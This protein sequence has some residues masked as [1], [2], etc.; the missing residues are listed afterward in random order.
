[1]ITKTSGSS[2]TNN[3]SRLWNGY[4]VEL[5]LVGKLAV[6]VGGGAVALRRTRALAPSNSLRD[7][8]EMLPVTK[9]GNATGCA[10][11]AV[12]SSACRAGCRP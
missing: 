8:T 10:S 1:M 6:V 7:T 5:D 3:P 11:G 2:S 12:V 4:P 9:P